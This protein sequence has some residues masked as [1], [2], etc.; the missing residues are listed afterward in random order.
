MGQRH[1]LYVIAN[2]C[3]RY[4]VLAAAHHQ[5]LY[6]RTAVRQC[7]NLLRILRSQTNRSPLRR[8]L[9]RAQGLYGDEEQSTV[10]K[11]QSDSEMPF[12]FTATC[13]LIGASLHEEYNYSSKV[14]LLPMEVSYSGWQNDDGI[15][16]YDITDPVNPRYGFVFLEER[17]EAG[18][19]EDEDG[20][21][22]NQGLLPA[23]AIIDAPTYLGGYYA[24][25]DLKGLDVDEL[26]AAFDDYSLITVAALESLWPGAGWSTTVQDGS[27]AP[28]TAGT[29][30][31]LK[32]N[33]LARTVDEAF[34]STTEDLDWLSDAERLPDFLPAI[35][36]KLQAAPDLIHTPPGVPL[37]VRA[38][39]GRSDIDLSMYSDLTPLQGA[40]IVKTIGDVS[41]GEPISLSMPDLP[42][43]T[44]ADLEMVV[45][46]GRIKAL[47]LGRTPLVEQ[48][49]LLE[50][51]AKT[52]VLET[53]QYP[54]L[55][56][57][58]L[59]LVTSPSTD[60]DIVNSGDSSEL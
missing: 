53:F 14:Q 60:T 43:W 15:S 8:E 41:N 44:S 42:T 4:R 31:T 57:R 32:D 45:S 26:L 49:D 33:A 36:L 21:I 50:L 27:I 25:D 12:P 46:A 5:W 35:L 6:G 59:E 47:H 37:L 54:A 23:K 13:L 30:S 17:Y 10:G 51:V 18:A 40:T 39:S 58:A 11:R 29:R 52:P 38:L 20:M 56:A 16:I 2:V 1:Q 19:D 3:D 9:R 22:D 48:A 34:N 28:E 55:F 24:R 7:I